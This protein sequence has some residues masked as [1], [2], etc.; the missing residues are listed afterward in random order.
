MSQ[1][2]QGEWRENAPTECPRGHPLNQPRSMLV[3]WCTHIDP[4]HRTWT[5]R[6]CGLVI[7]NLRA[8]QNVEPM[9]PVI[10]EHKEH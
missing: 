3:G 4:P 9:R 6:R 2:P 8:D 7:H 10:L 5:C 1:G